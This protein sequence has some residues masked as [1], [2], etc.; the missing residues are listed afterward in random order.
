[1]NSECVDPDMAILVVDDSTTTAGILCSLLRDAGFADVELVKDGQ[2]ALERL[3]I[4]KVSL[5][6]ARWRMFPMSGLQL[7]HRIRKDDTMSFIRFILVTASAHPQLPETVHRLGANG[8]ILKPF[9]AET[10]RV[11]IKRA[12]A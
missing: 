1:M 4:T 3:K 8:F 2:S 12:F 5:V 9:T 11:T 7:L 6:L 10:L